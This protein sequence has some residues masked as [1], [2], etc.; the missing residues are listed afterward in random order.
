[1]NHHHWDELFKLGDIIAKTTKVGESEAS[2]AY[3]FGFYQ[4]NCEEL[5]HCF[6]NYDEAFKNGM[7]VLKACKLVGPRYVRLSCDDPKS[8]HMLGDSKYEDD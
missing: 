5:H 8:V 7:K 6:Q 1:M 2:S 4:R 3:F